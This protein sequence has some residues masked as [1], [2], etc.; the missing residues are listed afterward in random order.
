MGDCPEI[1]PTLTQ[2]THSEVHSHIVTFLCD[3]HYKGDL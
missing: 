1:G 3:K 2:Q